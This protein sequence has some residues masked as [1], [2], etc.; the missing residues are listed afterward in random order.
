MNIMSKFLIF[1]FAC[2]CAAAPFT[3]CSSKGG[4]NAPPAQTTN[5]ITRRSI[6]S[7]QQ[8]A[9]NTPPISSATATATVTLNPA[10][11]N[12]SGTVTL[13]NFTAGATAVTINEGDIGANGS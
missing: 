3:A 6:L 9:S 13:S 10:T 1:L 5:G 2:I 11:G 12:L 8:I 4:G 7:D